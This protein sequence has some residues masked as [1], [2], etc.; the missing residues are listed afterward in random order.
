MWNRIINPINGKYVSV[1]DN[2]GKKILKNYIYHLTGGSD[3]VDNNIVPPTNGSSYTV[4]EI[5]TA[6]GSGG[7]Q[8]I[9]PKST[10]KISAEEKRKKLEA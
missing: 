5:K 7:T 1:N 6:L 3:A 10:G 9:K 8:R 2:L 4:D